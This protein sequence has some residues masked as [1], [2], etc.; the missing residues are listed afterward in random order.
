MPKKERKK[1]KEKSNQRVFQCAGKL[2]KIFFKSLYIK[3]VYGFF[4]MVHILQSFLF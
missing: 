2:E 3:P 1:N 4:P